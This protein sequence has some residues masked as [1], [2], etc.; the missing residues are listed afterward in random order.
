MEGMTSVDRPLLFKEFQQSGS[1]GPGGY[2]QL[3]LPCLVPVCA[4]I[5]IW[6]MFQTAAG[7]LQGRAGG[8]MI[9][10]HS[11]LW[12]WP[13]LLDEPG[14]QCRGL[15]RRLAGRIGLAAVIL[16][17]GKCTASRWRHCGLQ[18]TDLPFPGAWCKQLSHNSIFCGRPQ[19]FLGVWVGYRISWSSD[20]SLTHCFS[21]GWHE[22]Q[23]SLPLAPA[24]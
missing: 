13:Q 1:E 20:W 7:P 5:N 17:G 6:P 24:Y 12:L 23:V 21:S 4:R 11:W 3:G 14:N 9:T 19:P 15:G 2:L 16:K 18:K 22:L 10:Q 8:R